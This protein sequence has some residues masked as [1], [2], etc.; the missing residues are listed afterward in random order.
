MDEYWEEDDVIS[1][2]LDQCV[3]Q[4][5]AVP[6]K[7]L[8]DEF[9]EVGAK[10][11][12][13][14]KKSTFQ[15]RKKFGNYKLKG[16]MDEFYK[17]S[18]VMD[19]QIGISQQKVKIASEEKD[20][21]Y[22]NAVEDGKVAMLEE[23]LGSEQTKSKK[24]EEEYENKLKAKE[25]EYLKKVK[26]LKEALER[27]KNTN[28][29]LQ[30]E[31]NKILEEKEQE[32]EDL[33]VENTNLR[34]ELAS[35]ENDVYELALENEEL[36]DKVAISKEYIATLKLQL[37]NFEK[38]Q[39][40][41]KWKLEQADDLLEM[42]EKENDE[43]ERKYK[44]AF[45]NLVQQLKVEKIRNM[46][47]QCDNQLGTA[48]TNRSKSMP[49]HTTANTLGMLCKRPDIESKVDITQIRSVGKESWKEITENVKVPVV[50]K[51]LGW[52]QAFI[53]RKD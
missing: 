34:N 5:S 41:D 39:Q 12:T 9:V 50:L 26:S 46:K 17:L 13:M 10:V 52:T 47:L 19:E 4:L 11:D 43:M 6:E 29:E 44:V 8:L 20:A 28:K 33:T 38:Q 24:N 21:V 37:S 32:I 49:S 7:S 14:N 42:V 27:Q 25:E 45:T 2:L 40:Q 15:N 51:S 23:L 16:M 35:K 31:F 1:K 53:H 3:D 18:K 36:E 22:E 30:Y 48:G